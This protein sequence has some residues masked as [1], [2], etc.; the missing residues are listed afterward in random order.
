MNYLLDT[1]T[2]IWF[3]K[4]ENEL[5]KKIVKTIENSDA[6]VYVSI[7]SIWEL[8]IKISL[9][10]FSFPN[11]IEGFIKLVEENGFEILPITLA[12]TI[13]ISSL[14]YIH[15][16]PFD[17]IMIAQSLGNDLIIITKDSHI[18]KYTV[19]TLW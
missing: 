10:K 16:D 7:A 13:K 5:S 1:H 8:S 6:T 11:G 14:E 17:R 3:L 15:R 9:G 12:D 2:L 4:G 18:K 19:K